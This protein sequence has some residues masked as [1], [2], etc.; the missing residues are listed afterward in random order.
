MRFFR[1]RTSI[2]PEFWFANAYP[3][4]L[5]INSFTYFFNYFSEFFMPFRIFIRFV[6][7]SL[8][9]FG[10]ACSSCFIIIITNNNNNS[11]TYPNLKNLHANM[12]IVDLKARQ[13]TYQKNNIEW[14]IKLNIIL[15]IKISPRACDKIP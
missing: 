15:Y 14:K 3:F 9:I 10:L 6:F 5:M 13:R 2:I 12:C 1:R 7:I 11:L 8:N 4:P